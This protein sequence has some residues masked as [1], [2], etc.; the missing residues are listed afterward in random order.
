MRDSSSMSSGYHRLAQGDELLRRGGVDADR[1]V[2]L[3]LGRS[4]LHGDRDALDDLGGFGPDHVRADHLAARAIDDELHENLLFASRERMLERAEAGLVDLDRAEALARLLFRQPDRG[5][6]R[7][8]EHGGRH[9]LVLWRSQLAAEQRLCERAALGGRHRREIDAVGDVA[10][11]VDRLDRAPGMRIDQHFADRPELHARGL[12]AQALAVRHAPGGE[13]HQLGARVLAVAVGD[14]ER[15]VGLT[16]DGDRLGAEVQHYS[17]FLDLLA[18]ARAELSVELAQ[19][20]VAPVGER[21]L[22]AQ[23]VEDR[24]ELDRDVAAAHHDRAPRQALEA[25][26]LVRSERE[27]L[28][29]DVRDLRARTGG[30]ENVLRAPAASRDLHGVGI[31]DNRA[32][33]Q[34]LGA[35]ADERAL[36][37]RVQ[38][39]HLPILAGDE[40]RPVECRLADAPAVADRVLEVVAKMR[41]IGE[42]LLRDAADVHTGAAEAVAFRYRDA[43]AVLRGEA[44]RAHSARAAADREQVEIVARHGRRRSCAPVTSGSAG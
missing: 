38:A 34:D 3:R 1:G 11:G 5:E 18:Q 14:L 12:E 10:D 30:D 22:H 20:A 19:Q 44:A 9:V 43:R 32:P 15:A 33:A 25:E 28:A 37:H 41:R 42:Q 21:R 6:V 13:Q 35:R 24:G 4:E 39:R 16:R 26:H 8:G 40:L 29:W 2:E 36:V 17:L 27:R 7:V 23:P 31:D